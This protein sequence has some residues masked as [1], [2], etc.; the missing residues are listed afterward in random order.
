MTRRAPAIGPPGCGQPDTTG[1]EHR[2]RGSRL[3]LGGVEYRPRTRHH[4]ASNQ[5]RHVHRDVVV[6]LH[7]RVLVHQHLLGKAGPVGQP[8]NLLAV[9]HHARPLVGFALSR[10]AVDT[11][12]GGARQAHRAIAAEDRHPRDHVIAGSEIGNLLAHRFNDPGGLMA[13]NDRRRKRHLPFNHVQIAVA[14][15]ACDQ[16]HQHLAPVRSVDINLFNL[17]WLAHSVKH[18]C[19][20]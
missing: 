18:R 11:L 7:Q 15:A 4:P 3:H 8:A 12:V 17:K 2:D 10:N 20:H 19:L 6:D 13:E 9:E 5:R 1:T 16:T 14:D